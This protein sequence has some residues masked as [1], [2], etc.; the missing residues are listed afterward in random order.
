M[1]NPNGK[2]P[3]PMQVALLHGPYFL[4]LL[5]LLLV[6]AGLFAHETDAVSITS[7][8]LGGLLGAFSA[9]AV[10]I[11]GPVEMSKDSW[12]A[13]L[14]GARV[15]EVIAQTP[16]DA[17]PR[18]IETA[19]LESV[20]IGPTTTVLELLTL[21]RSGGWSVGQTSGSSTATLTTFIRKAVDLPNGGRLSP[22][23]ILTITVPVDSLLG[24]VPPH[25]LA[26]VQAV[27]FQTPTR[28][29]QD[30]GHAG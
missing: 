4:A 10:R 13:T 15:W 8:V 7:I 14:I 5:S 22:G 1:T 29:V 16:G 25:V 27:G 19:P 28:P 17:E 6:A 3:A 20:E 24:P 26:V 30:A 21:A 12:K 18:V 23:D 11:E 2:L 9:V